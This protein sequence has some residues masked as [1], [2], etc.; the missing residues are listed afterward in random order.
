MD[1]IHEKENVLIKG[2][3]DLIEL[4]EKEQKIYE[5]YSH[6]LSRDHKLWEAAQKYALEKAKDDI[7]L[8]LAIQLA[9]QIG[10]RWADENPKK[11]YKHET[12]D[13]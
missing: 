12:K 5:T 13:L 3:E 6:N 4:L 2:F 11:H 9:F 10:A 1:N 8:R 7:G